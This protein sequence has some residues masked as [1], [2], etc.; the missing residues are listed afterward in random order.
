MLQLFF[1]THLAFL[2]IP[3]ITLAL[4]PN[5]PTSLC[6]R[7]VGDQDKTACL[8]KV[9]N[10]DLDWYAASAC[11]LQQDD[12]QFTKCLD[13]IKSASF[14]PEALELC[15]KNPEST[16]SVRLGCLK[17]IKN[18]N[19]TRAQ[20]KSCSESGNSGAIEKCLSQETPR[21]PASSAPQGIYQSLEIQK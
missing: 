13:E 5:N 18:K 4:E 16:D 17:K 6:D 15:A 9:S 8:K 10:M 2:L 19:Y 12:G 7:Y 21:T 1:K 11:S 20:I 3:L 14:S